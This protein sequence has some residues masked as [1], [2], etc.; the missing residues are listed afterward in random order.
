M[1]VLVLVRHVRVAWAGQYSSAIPV[2]PDV[3]HARRLNV[4]LLHVV[5][6]C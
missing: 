4:S 2:E 5:L 3:K 6:R 1:L